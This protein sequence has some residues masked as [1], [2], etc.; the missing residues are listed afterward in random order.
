MYRPSPDRTTQQNRWTE[1]EKDRDRQRER[2]REVYSGRQNKR[3]VRWCVCVCRCANAC[4]VCR[5]K[6]LSVN[7]L[8]Q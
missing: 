8:F 3:A 5:L 1:R 4:S 2:E 7:I 6:M